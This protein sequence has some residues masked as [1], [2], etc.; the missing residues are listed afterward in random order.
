[1]E[2]AHH[3]KTVGLVSSTLNSSCPVCNN[4]DSNLS[5][6]QKLSDNPELTTD[7][8]LG[9]HFYT[10]STKN[11]NHHSHVAHGRHQQLFNCTMAREVVTWSNGVH[12]QK[13]GSSWNRTQ[14]YVMSLHGP[15]LCQISDGTTYSA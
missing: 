4:P 7:S 5:I 14:T 10:G 15:T 8:T 13:T 12:L 11:D 6:H 9:E 3:A 2:D 1:M